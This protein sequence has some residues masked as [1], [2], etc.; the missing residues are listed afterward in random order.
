MPAPADLG[1]ASTGQT[2]Y[3]SGNS[4]YVDGHPLAEPYLPAD[5]PLG[6]PIA[7]RQHPYRVLP[8]EF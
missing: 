2:I 1:P 4:I 3:S 8:G 5:G 6:P 7:A